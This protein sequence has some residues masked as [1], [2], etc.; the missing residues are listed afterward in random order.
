MQSDLEM[1]DLEMVKSRSWSQEKGS[2]KQ[3]SSRYQ[4]CTDKFDQEETKMHKLTTML[5]DRRTNRQMDSERSQ[6]RVLCIC[7]CTCSSF[8]NSL[9]SQYQHI[10][11]TK[12]NDKS[13]DK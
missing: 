1:V 12:I 9:L 5:T 13:E 3:I 8:T 11:M 6:I 10:S 7:I 4:V 2:V